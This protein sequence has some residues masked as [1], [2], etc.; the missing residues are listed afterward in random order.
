LILFG[1]IVNLCFDYDPVSTHH[2]EHVGKIC[3]NPSGQRM[4]DGHD[5]KLQY[6]DRTYVFRMTMFEPDDIAKKRALLSGVVKHT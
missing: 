5:S 1:H 2:A 3:L 6:L 4:T